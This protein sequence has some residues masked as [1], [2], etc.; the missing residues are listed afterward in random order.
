ML[1][2]T[3]LLASCSCVAVQFVHSVF[4]PFIFF[5]H[6]TSI[7]LVKYAVLLPEDLSVFVADLSHV[8]TL[9]GFTFR[10]NNHLRVTAQHDFLL[11]GRVGL[12]S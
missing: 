12:G 2:P 6:N 3:T 5:L 7:I 8:S 11:F 10:A 9:L 4:H 1:T